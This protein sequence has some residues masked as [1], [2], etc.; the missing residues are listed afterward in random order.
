MLPTVTMILQALD[1]PC[2]SLPRPPAAAP[3]PPTT[4][5]D[6]TPPLAAVYRRC[7]VTA[8]PHPRADQAFTEGEQMD[9]CIMRMPE[10][11]FY[12]WSV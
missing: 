12:Y 5:A 9:A 1:L 7:F 4:R 2:P 3:L 6:A 8:S 11:P 10:D